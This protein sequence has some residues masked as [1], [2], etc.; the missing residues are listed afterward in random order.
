MLVVVADATVVAP[1]ATLSV[2]WSVLFTRPVTFFCTVRFTGELQLARS[3]ELLRPVVMSEPLW[4]SVVGSYRRTVDPLPSST[5]PS[6]SNAMPFTPVNP[7][8]SDF[9]S[10]AV[11]VMSAP[12]A[13]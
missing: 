8:L 3:V 5:D 1:F 12:P 13:V 4:A 7:L 6:V 11:R 2:N 10:V 9:G